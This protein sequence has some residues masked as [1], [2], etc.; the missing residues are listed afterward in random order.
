MAKRITDEE[1][2][3][4]CEER[5]FIYISR[6]DGIQ[7]IICKD[8]DDYYYNVNYT[9][10]R[11]S[12]PTPF[13]VNNKYVIDNIK[14]YLNNN[15][16]GLTLISTEYHGYD[17]PLRFSYVDQNG[18][19]RFCTKL[20]RSI[21][22]GCGEKNFRTHEDFVDELH[23]LRPNITVLGEFIDTYHRVECK[24]NDCG[25]IWKAD[26]TLLLYKDV[27]Y[28]G[29]PVCI[30][31]KIKDERK[32]SHETFVQEVSSLF[33]D[34]RV[35]GEYV[36]ARTPIEIYCEKHNNAFLITPHHLLS[37]KTSCEE[38]E[39]DKIHAKRITPNNV[40]IEKQKSL[41]PSLE[42]LSCY[43]GGKNEIL[44]KCKVCNHIWST[45][46]NR[47]FRSSEHCPKCGIKSYGEGCIVEWLDKNNISYTRE[48]TF[49]GLIGVG[50]GLLSYDFFVPEYNLLIEFQGGQHIKPVPLFGG[51]AQFEKQKEHDR[52]KRIYAKENG[53]N[54]LEIWFNEI[55]NID[56]ILSEY[57]ISTTRIYVCGADED[58]A[59]DELFI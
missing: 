10:L 51:K 46:A 54:F 5:G 3:S 39:L 26:P 7:R 33:R 24:C 34:Y 45:K 48:K 41:N 49:D 31:N 35:I 58:D 9:N 40:F 6:A 20:F 22:N 50:G 1:L 25:T 15:N 13:G 12:T 38:C 8:K 55:G 57:L 17:K 2:S 42:F 37:G 4:L 27:D 59:D 52:R 18:I 19:T 21:L 30:K 47:F 16:V 11:K 23:L 36:N 29:C 56:S 44:V 43:D 32:K 53:Y 28:I 14:K